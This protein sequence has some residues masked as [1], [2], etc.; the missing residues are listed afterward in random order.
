MKKLIC[1]LLALALAFVLA[2]CTAKDDP[3]DAEEPAVSFA[4]VYDIVRIDAGEASVSEDELQMLRQRGDEAYL[5]LSED[6][7]GLM[8]IA[9]DEQEFTYDPETGVI[10]MDGVDSVMDFGEDG[11]PIVTDQN[12]SMTLRKRPED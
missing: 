10:H 9:G 2:A 5:S 1:I 12:G 4:G 11:L 6:G 8:C 3:G 7:T